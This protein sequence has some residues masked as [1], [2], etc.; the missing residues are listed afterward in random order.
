MTQLLPLAGT[1]SAANALLR[2][3]YTHDAMIDLLLAKPGITNNELAEHFGYSAVWVSRIINSDAFNVR[4]AERKAVLIDPTITASLEERLKTVASKSADVV[5]EKLHLTPTSDFALRAMEV[6]SKA[7]GYGARQVGNTVNN[8]FVVA[9]PP[10]A[11]SESE[12]MAQNAPVAVQV[13]G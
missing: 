12:W 9:L 10:K 2:V 13:S 11:A 7:L 6:A 5:L 8:N 4:M 3:H 1:E